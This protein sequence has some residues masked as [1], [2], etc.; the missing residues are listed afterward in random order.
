MAAGRQELVL[1]ARPQ[2]DLLLPAPRALPAQP[3]GRPGRRVH[4]ALRQLGARHRAQR[5]VRGAHGAH[6]QRQDPTPQHDGLDGRARPRLLP[7]ARHGVAVEEPGLDAGA[8][9]W[10]CCR[11]LGV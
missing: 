8:A 11:Q 10:E 1:H 3:D 2:R 5:R 9:E 4:L 6:V 7:A